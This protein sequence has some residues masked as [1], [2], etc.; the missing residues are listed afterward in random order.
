MNKTLA[1][2]AQAVQI[3]SQYPRKYQE[4]DSTG[5]EETPLGLHLVLL[6]SENSARSSPSCL[7][8]STVHAACPSS[9]KLL[10]QRR[11]QSSNLGAADHY[12]SVGEIEIE[13]D[14]S[15]CCGAVK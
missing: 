14:R 6:N 15:S 5:G 13:I 4:G 8:F 9:E 3:I 2:R 1:I 12:A 10:S 7:D 11:S